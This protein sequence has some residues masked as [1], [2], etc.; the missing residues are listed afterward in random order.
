MLKTVF[1][2]LII[3]F[4]FV[5]PFAPLSIIDKIKKLLNIASATHASLCPNGPCTINYHDIQL[6][7]SQNLNDG[8]H[9]ALH[10]L[11][12]HW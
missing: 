11:P 2:L 10:R 6:L 3:P 12:N 7:R 9:D 5:L 4:R 1:V 8:R